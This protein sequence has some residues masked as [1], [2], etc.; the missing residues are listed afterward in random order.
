MNTQKIPVRTTI[1]RVTEGGVSAYSWYVVTLDGATV[2]GGYGA[3]E[4]DARN[5]AGIWLAGHHEYIDTSSKKDIIRGSL[6][7]YG[8]YQSDDGE[9]IL[10]Q[11]AAT[12]D[13]KWVV[14]AYARDS[15]T[16]TYRGPFATQVDAETAADE[17]ENEWRG[18]GE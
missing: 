8:S 10:T 7:A 4:V 13:G 3:T 11:L 9:I 1:E 12:K 16:E 15:G 2:A 18:F 17:I 5:D 14:R 6:S